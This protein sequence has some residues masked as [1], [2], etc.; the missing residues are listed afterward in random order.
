MKAVAGI[1]GKRLT[2]KQLIGAAGE[3]IRGYR[4]KKRWGRGK[5]VRKRTVT[6]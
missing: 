1:G 5:L 4:P 6:P 2:Y 3:E